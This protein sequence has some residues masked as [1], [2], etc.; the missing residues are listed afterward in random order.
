VGIYTQGDILVINTAAGLGQPLSR[1]AGYLCFPWKDATGI[2]DEVEVASIGPELEALLEKHGKGG[3]KV[4]GFPMTI[5]FGSA[6]QGD[7]TSYRCVLTDAKG[8]KVEGAILSDSGTI[9]RSTAPGMVTFYPFDPLPR[10]KLN[11]TWSWEVDG[12]ARTL[13]ASFSTK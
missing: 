4:V 8:E 2:P 10:G 6:V 7:P 12:A 13:S 5:H 9:R 11:A 1:G 3:R